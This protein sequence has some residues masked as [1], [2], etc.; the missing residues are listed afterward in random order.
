MP[1]ISYSKLINYYFLWKDMTF[2][3]LSIS[4][5]IMMF[6]IYRIFI[7]KLIWKKVIFS[8]SSW[9]FAGK[10][11]SS[12]F[13]SKILWATLSKD[14][15]VLSHT[16]KSMP[17]DLRKNLRRSSKNWS[18]S[19]TVVPRWEINFNLSL[20]KANSSLSVSQNLKGMKLLMRLLSRFCFKIRLILEKGQSSKV[21][22]IW[23]I[24]I[25]VQF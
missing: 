20:R 18:Q 22:S 17:S 10:S 9:G 24:N 5:F 6:N 13:T 12:T 11:P 23:T 4:W 8:R 21:K 19:R 15:R 25:K 16:S 7:V 1:L 14:C 3:S 2:F